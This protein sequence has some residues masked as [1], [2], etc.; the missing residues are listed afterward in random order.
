MEKH[1]Q[2]PPKNGV[3]AS[4]GTFTLI[5]SDKT[6]PDS[7]R[8]VM[9]LAYDEL[10]AIAAHHCRKERP[11]R[12]MQPTALVNEAYL[13]LIK[14]DVTF[15]N[16]KHFFCTA[17]RA[18]RRILVDTARRRKAKIRGGNWHRTDFTEAERIGFEQPSD[19]LDFE[20]ALARLEALDRRLSEIVELRVFGG[21]SNN[22]AAMILGMGN[23]TA[24]RQWSNAKKWLRDAIGNAGRSEDSNR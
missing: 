24:R 2:T 19:F 21:C 16:R 9:A 15:K 11:S 13:R 22:E 7:L 23:A 12:T 18:M 20:T 14:S 10:R 6:N 8:T 5:L 3:Q 4:A 17:S 1:R